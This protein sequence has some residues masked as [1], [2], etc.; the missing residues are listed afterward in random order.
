MKKISLLFLC[1]CSLQAV[2][3][4]DSLKAIAE[5]NVFQQN[6]NEEFKDRE[7]SPLGSAD[8]KNFKGHDFFP[9]DLHYRVNAKL[10][11]TDGTPFFD[12]KTT[13]SRVSTE[14]VYGNIAF[15][16]AGREFQ[17]PVY[18]SKDL[19]QTT[20]YSDYLFF[21]FTDETNGNETYGGGR[22]IDLRIPKGG[23]DSLVIDFNMAYN[24][25]C[26]YSH[27][28]SCPIVPAENQMDIEVPVGVKYFKKEETKTSDVSQTDEV[29]RTVDVQPEYPG[30]LGALATFISKN[31]KY[32]KEAVKQKIQGNVYVEFIVGRDGS[33]SDVKTIRGISKECDMEAERVIS[34]MPR[35]KPGQ[36]DGANVVVRFVQPIHFKGKAGWKKL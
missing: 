13:S 4:T 3:Q 27:M 23:G 1:I 11:R 24:P 12:M 35:W 25:Y 29:Y 5:I 10:T 22:Y 20:E 34:M 31:L 6:L 14:R 19:M 21:P 17:L 26:A 9:I 30:G 28:F 7:K 18:Q 33:I 16:L 32:P 15:V 8:F 2:A 36:I